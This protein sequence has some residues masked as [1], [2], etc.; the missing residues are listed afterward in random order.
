MAINSIG[1]LIFVII[2]CVTYFVAPKKVKW[3]VLLIASYVFY[4]TSSTKLIAFMIITTVSI[5]LAALKMN[6]IEEQAQIKGT[7]L[8][9]DEKK[10]IKEQTKKKKKIIIILTL[11][12]N[13]G[14]LVG[15]KYCNFISGNINSILNMFHISME[16]PFM[17]IVLPL[18]ISF[19][20][21]QATSY[22]IDVY[23][24]K[25]K[26]DKNLGRIAL[27]VSFFPQIVEGPI[28]RYDRLAKQLYEPHFFDYTNAKY[29]IQLMAWGFFKK[30][31]IAD[32]AA[33]LVDIVFANYT[34]YTGIVTILAIMLYTL[35]IYTEFSGCMDI[36]RGVAQILGIHLDK[37]FQRPFFSKSI[38]EFWRRW[39]I[40]L[41]TWLK[42]YVFYSVSFSKVCMKI[43]NAGKKVF[44]GHIGKLIP[45]A[46]A[47]F[48]V[49]FSNGLWHGASW[50]YICYGLYYYAIMMIGMLFEPVGKKIIE[51]LKINIHT[52]SYRLFQIMR[53][54]GFV[55][56]GM[57]I[58]RSP[59][60]KTAFVML[61]SACSFSNIGM[62]FDGR[63]FSIGLQPG[64]YVI[65]AV[66][67]VLIIMVGL[68]QEKGYS[69]R[70]K[71][72]QQNL[73]FRWILYYGI[74]FAILLLGIY[75][76]GYNVSSFIYGQF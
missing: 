69:I 35:Q 34:E 44:K 25:Y 54:T 5:Y 17:K 67:I 71:I 13:F 52:F 38:Q 24:G 56:I 61:R 15:L 48:F 26:A 14:I 40:T 16:I 22:L 49:W 33:I 12:L 55:F 63:I 1:F 11:L 19:Y 64:D 50:K 47:L 39:N 8:E 45:A 58:F 53:T 60:L 41:G 31:V 4:F 62:L 37:N 32:R 73:V 9:K 76:A 72:A 10:K 29:G 51:K 70:E 59:N 20:T 75:G 74:F 7:D 46:F 66:S 23:R 2:V 30:M 57:L 65:L 36:V 43:T 68:L 21:L 28:G 42:D 18:G 6:Q 27:F 3:V